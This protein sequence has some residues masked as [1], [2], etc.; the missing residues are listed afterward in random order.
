M[1]LD[2]R[3]GEGGAAVAFESLG[4][5]PER[6]ASRDSLGN[7]AALDYFEELSRAL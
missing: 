5:A 7:P 2:Q 6:A 4:E 3:V 1:G